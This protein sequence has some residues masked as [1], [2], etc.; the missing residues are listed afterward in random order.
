MNIKQDVK[1]ILSKHYE[2]PDK[3]KL[4]VPYLILHKELVE[5]INLV[6]DTR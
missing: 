3:L 5:Y 1:D 4:N 6:L 2:H